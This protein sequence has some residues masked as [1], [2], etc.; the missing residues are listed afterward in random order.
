MRYLCDEQQLLQY[1]CFIIQSEN[2]T[3]MCHPLNCPR[4]CPG[5]MPVYWIVLIVPEGFYIETLLIVD[6]VGLSY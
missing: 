6:E 5:E 3:E 2:L 1:Q 4:M